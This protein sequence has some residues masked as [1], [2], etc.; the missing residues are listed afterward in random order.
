MTLIL[1]PACLQPVDARTFAD[2][3]LTGLQQSGDIAAV[4]QYVLQAEIASRWLTPTIIKPSLYQ[5]LWRLRF[6]TQTLELSTTRVIEQLV[7][8]LGCD[9]VDVGAHVGYFSIIAT[10][11]G[12]ASV[13]AVEMHEPNWRLLKANVPS[14]VAVLAAAGEAPQ[15]LQYF[16]GRGHSNHSLM[17]RGDTS[18]ERSTTAMVTLDT[19]A[20]W[21]SDGRPCVVKI[22]VQGHEEKVLRGF[23][24]G[25]SPGGPIII[26][27]VERTAGPELDAT[28]QDAIRLLQSCAYRLF[29]IQDRALVEIMGASDDLTR[30]LPKSS[31]LLAVSSGGFAAFQDALY[32]R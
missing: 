12:A 18:R 28:Y 20:P 15:E 17:S 6:F 27:E 9:F 3:M 8:V 13:T 16:V 11:A 5:Q 26:L 31:N 22:D 10:D 19:L 25:L 1:R 4:E 32:A 30:S 7:R 21:A 29:S 23:R 24:R 2:I 14:A